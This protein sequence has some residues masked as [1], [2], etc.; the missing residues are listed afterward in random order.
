MA[1]LAKLPAAAGR[2]RQSSLDFV[3][4]NVS[5]SKGSQCGLDENAWRETAGER[6]EQRRSRLQVAVQGSRNRELAI[7]KCSQLASQ[8][9]VQGTEEKR[10]RC[11]PRF[12]GPCCAESASRPKFPS[13]C[14]PWARELAAPTLL[15]PNSKKV[16][17]PLTRHRPL[18]LEVWKVV[19]VPA[20]S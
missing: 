20:R 12:S 5:R 16:G 15:A 17:F 1:R 8:P 6:F 10:R 4:E 7:E 11:W 13:P 3:R 14:S 2:R 18:Q 9:T 19:F